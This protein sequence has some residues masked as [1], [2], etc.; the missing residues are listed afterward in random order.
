MNPN[1]E[2]RHIPEQSLDFFPTKV[3]RIEIGEVL[4]AIITDHPENS[5]NY[6]RVLALVTLHGQPLG[7]VKLEFSDTESNSGQISPATYRSDLWATLGEAINQH[8]QADGVS[9]VED[10]PL[11]GF[12]SVSD[13][14]CLQSR[15]ELLE[16]APFVSVVIATH[17][18]TKSLA[19]CI[20][21]LL[22]MDY[23]A[24][25]I[26]VVD[27]A[28]ASSDTADY[29]RQTY[30]NSSKVRYVREDF[31]GGATA[32]NRGLLEVKDAPIVAFTDDD[33]LVD[34]YWLAELVKGFSAAE[35][36]ACVTGMI[37]PAELE[38]P[39]QALVEQ[40]GFGKGFSQRIFDLGAHRLPNPLYPFTAGSFGSGASM[41]FKMSFL[42]EVAGF[43]PALGPG[44][45]ACGGEDLALLFKAVNS[46]HRLVY[47]PSAILYH[48]HGR[49]Y[50]SLRRQAFSYGV[51]LTAYLTS[52]ILD[53][54]G[55]IL[56]ILGRIPAGLR[57]IFDPQSAKNAKM[58]ADYPR[59][60]ITQ[61]R[62]GMLR[63]PI[64]YLRSRYRSRRMR[65]QRRLLQTVHT[66]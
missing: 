53:K 47:Q 23:P 40:Y 36:V 14:A 41:A 59:E 45:I 35:D 61:E 31:A 64:F 19:A 18:R 9:Q 50:A 55:L 34:R 58:Q 60:L 17:N 30:P 27:N 44:T 43:D 56:R 51:G 21:S 48:F 25:E 12:E 54:P 10:L 28:P 57:Y 49:D 42:R 5:Q 3:V 65:E 46:G 26:I 22:D 20:Q 4:P 37:F 33:V 52:V 16:K 39:T 62:L 38:T 29:I 2:T 63:G 13:P 6:R 66:T 7:T 32:H 11:N 1:I 15:R 24:F 8:L